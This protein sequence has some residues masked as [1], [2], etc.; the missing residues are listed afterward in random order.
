MMHSQFLIAG[1]F[2]RICFALVEACALLVLLFKLPKAQKE[3]YVHIDKKPQI[4]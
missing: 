2:I 3:T 1:F 4:K